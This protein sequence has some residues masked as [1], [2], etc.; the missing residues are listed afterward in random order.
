MATRPQGGTGAPASHL[1]AGLARRIFFFMAD[2][3]DPPTPTMA[4]D[5]V[6]GMRVERALAAGTEEFEA[7]LYFFCS[8][9]CKQTFRVNPR[10]YARSAGDA[11]FLDD[12]ETN[13]FGP[14]GDRG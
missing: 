3:E 14:G 6:C 7:H 13:A 10:H 4:V 1:A 2:R 8:A 9:S 12:P 11:A 5:P